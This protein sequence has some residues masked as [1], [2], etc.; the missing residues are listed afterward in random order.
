M[1]QT[2]APAGAQSARADG[3][4]QLHQVRLPTRCQTPGPR[5]VGGAGLSRVLDPRESL[6]IQS[7]SACGRT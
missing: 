1:P 4:R 6:S 3:A 2:T 5:G 7:T